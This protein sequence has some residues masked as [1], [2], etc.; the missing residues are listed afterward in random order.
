MTG[1]KVEAM[2]SPVDPTA[3]VILTAMKEYGMFLADNGADA[4]VDRASSAF[5]NFRDAQVFALL[6]PAVR[7]LGQANGFT[8]QLQNSSGMSREQAK[9]EIERRGGTSEFR[10]SC[11]NNS[12]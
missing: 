1:G 4:I 7:G 11:R 8:M 10:M 2:D 6:P 12:S 3:Q 5:R 9:E